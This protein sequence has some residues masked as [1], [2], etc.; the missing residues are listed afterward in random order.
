MRINIDFSNISKNNVSLLY[1]HR[2]MLFIVVELRARARFKIKANVLP[3]RCVYSTFCNWLGHLSLIIFKCYEC[4][5]HIQADNTFWWFLKITIRLPSITDFVMI[6]KK[7]Y[8]HFT[9]F[10]IS[11]HAL[12][13]GFF[14]GQFNLLTWSVGVNNYASVLKMQ[15]RKYVQL[16]VRWHRMHTINQLQWNILQINV[17]NKSTSLACVLNHV[18]EF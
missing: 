10:I 3:N 8:S 5:S 15:C 7:S 13:T 17:D 11:L 16:Y 9:L 12:A 6:K 1:F 14:L 18:N 4:N 2:I